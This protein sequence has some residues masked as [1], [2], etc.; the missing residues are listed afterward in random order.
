[1]GIVKAFAGALSGTLADQW[2]DIITVDKFDEQTL[3]M[4]GKFQSKNRWRG[5]NTEGSDGIITNGSKIYVPEN[6]AAF[7]FS[8]G[9]IEGVITDPGGYIYQTGESSILNG[10]SIDNMLNQIGD[11]FRF[12]GVP[13]VQ[14]RVSFVNLREI[15]NIKFG[16]RGPLVYNDLFYKVDLGILSYGTFTLQVV[17]AKK[18]IRNFIPAN[19]AYYSFADLNT[20]QALLSDFLQSFIVVLNSLSEKYRISSLPA[21][22]NEISDIIAQDAHNA[23]TWEE[24]FGLK[25]CKV[26]IENIE[27]TEDSNELVKEYN[28]SRMSVSA[29]EGMSEQVANMAAQ[30][31]IA[32]GVKNNGLGNGGGIVMGMNVAQGMNPLNGQTANA[33]SN[34]SFTQITEFKKL[35]DAGIITEEEFNIKKKELLGL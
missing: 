10:G 6:T 17:D 3:C 19:A 7:V 4:P 29:Y 12:G 23:G 34:N 25:I 14:K 13:N 5:S 26:S 2:L 9:G 33:G 16:T 32:E 27:F 21:H 15:R 11:R 31:K 8:Q 1:M 35:L 24:R 18:V 20:R 30:Q 22:A 28:K